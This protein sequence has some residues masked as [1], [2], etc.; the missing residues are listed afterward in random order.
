MEVN[1]TVYGYNED[2]N[3]TF[4]ICQI[5][6]AV[7]AILGNGLV[8]ICFLIDNNLRNRQHYHLFSLAV[9]DIF[10]AMFGTLTSIPN[11]IGYPKNNILCLISI[12]STTTFHLTSVYNKISLSINRYW[13]TV[14]YISYFKYNELIY[15]NSKYNYILCLILC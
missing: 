13:A 10:S 6:S 14:C 3:W 9:A 11:H 15:T 8:I 2:I 1:S 4:N 12:A 7:F 5:I